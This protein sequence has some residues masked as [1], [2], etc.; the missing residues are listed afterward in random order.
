MT[1][2]RKALEQA[3]A[4][5]EIVSP[6]KGKVQGWKHFENGDKFEVDAPLDNANAQ[7]YDALL[8]PGGVANLD[9]LRIISK[10]VNFVRQFLEAGKPVAAICHAH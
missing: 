10:A 3:G 4:K 2:R 1:E 9:Q 8:L 6:A 5:T 7:A